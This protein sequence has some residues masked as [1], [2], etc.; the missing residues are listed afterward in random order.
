VSQQINLLGPQFRK[1]E[2]LLSAGLMAAGAGTAFLLMALAAGGFYFSTGRQAQQVAESAN[3]LAAGEA[4]LARLMQERDPVAQAK[5]LDGE[6]ARLEGAQK[7]KREVVALL[8]S[9]EVGDTKGYSDYLR[10]FARQIVD[11]VWLTGFDIA[12]AGR[13]ITLEGGAL[14]A[15]LVPLYIKRLRDEPAMQGR[16]FAM[17]ALLPSKVEAKEEKKEGE[18]SVP[19]SAKAPTPANYLAFTLS[20]ELEQPGTGGGASTRPTS[21]AERYAEYAKIAQEAQKGGQ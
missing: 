7:D 5:L 3:A 19:E 10:A 8:Q 11:G 1:R 15:D 2:V 9:G 6:I 17:L 16:Q 4:R 18:V 20:S 13:R 14:R 21:Q 12:A